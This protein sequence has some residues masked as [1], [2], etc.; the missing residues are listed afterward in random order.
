MRRI[1]F[2]LRTLMIVV[3][4][5]AVF[6]SRWVN[7]RER[8]AYH[9]QELS[10]VLVSDLEIYLM[11]T[12]VQGVPDEVLQPQRDAVKPICEL[13]YYHYDMVEKY[14]AAFRR[15][16]LPVPPDPPAPV[17]S[18]EY[19]QA[20]RSRYLDPIYRSIDEAPQLTPSSGPR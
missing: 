16:W 12:P 5:L 9:R 17:V 13:R 3:A 6:L 7:L 19:Q 15:P 18:I 11:L 2:R 1:R 14:E 8:I 20:F 10:K 4:L